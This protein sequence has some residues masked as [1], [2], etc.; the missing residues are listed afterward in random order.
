[1][2]D[3]MIGL[4]FNSKNGYCNSYHSACTNY[5][6]IRVSYPPVSINRSIQLLSGKRLFYF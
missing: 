2:N 3:E 5:S 4:F 1:L 6:F